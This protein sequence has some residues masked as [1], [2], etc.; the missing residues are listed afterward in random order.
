MNRLIWGT[1]LTLVC[2]VSAG[3]AVEIAQADKPD[4]NLVN[5]VVLDGPQSLTVEKGSILRVTGSTP[6]GGII[7][8]SISGRGKLHRQTRL[9]TY[10]DGHPMIGALMMEF[11]IEATDPGELTILVSKQTFDRTLKPTVEKYV[12]TVK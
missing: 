4:D 2:V 6:S 7:Q 3:F 5:V 8:T 12:V 10:R 11:E 1:L 9:S